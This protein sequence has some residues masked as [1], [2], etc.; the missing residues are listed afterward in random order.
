M[1][2]NL[3]PGTDEITDSKSAQKSG[4]NRIHVPNDP[5]LRC[6]WTS[7]RS[8]LVLALCFLHSDW[9]SP[10]IVSQHL[11]TGSL[12]FICGWPSFSE[13][14][15]L[16]HLIL[17]WVY[18]S[19]SVLRGYWPYLSC[20]VNYLQHRPRAYSKWGYIPVRTNR[21]LKRPYV[22]SQCGR[23]RWNFLLCTILTT[24]CPHLDQSPINLADGLIVAVTLSCWEPGSITNILFHH[25]PRIS[26]H[27]PGISVYSPSR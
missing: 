14:A 11:G 19:H 7:A 18:S 27:G 22:R 8:W 3:D 24:T 25:L 1:F 10:Q 6:V 21:P 4:M 20:I 5:C 26:L 17:E 12:N 2:T 16:V 13:S 9:M 15:T 23:M